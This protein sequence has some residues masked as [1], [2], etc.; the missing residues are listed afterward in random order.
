MY[1]LKYLL[2]QTQHI[3]CVTCC[4]YCNKYTMFTDQTDM[5]KGCWLLCHYYCWL[6]YGM[7]E[8]NATRLL[9]SL[10]KMIGW[11]LPNDSADICGWTHGE[12]C[13]KK[14]KRPIW[15]NEIWLSVI[16]RTPGIYR[17]FKWNL[18]RSVGRM[19]YIRNAYKILSGRHGRKWTLVRQA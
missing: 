9:H 15:L 14:V 13:Q 18:I 7:L 11:I 8:I 5:F 16:G 19:G 12:K 1:F 17:I 4:I 10:H 2:Q 6:P 3:T